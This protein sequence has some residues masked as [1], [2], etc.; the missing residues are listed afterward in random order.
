MSN[1]LDNKDW[2]MLAGALLSGGIAW[3]SM[4]AKLTAQDEKIAQLATVPE[5]LATLNAQV[6]SIDKRTTDTQLDVRDIRK[7]LLRLTEHG[8]SGLTNLSR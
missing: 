3:G 7:Y 4:S 6:S 1:K 8:D 5:N 2:L